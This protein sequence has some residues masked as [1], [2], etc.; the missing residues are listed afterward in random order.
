MGDEDTDM[1]ALAQLQRRAASGAVN[2]GEIGRDGKMRSAEEMRA[3]GI[4]SGNISVLGPNAE[5]MKLS[6]ASRAAR[7]RQ[8]EVVNRFEERRRMAE[9]VVPVKNSDVRALLRKMEQPV[10]LF[11]E[12]E[13]DRRDRLR[14]L[15]AGMDEGQREAVTGQVA[16]EAAILE[17][18]RT[19]QTEA[20]LTVGESRL[21]ETRA[22]LALGSLAKARERVARQKAMTDA[23]YLEVDR[24]Q[25]R[26]AR[27]L[28][29]L[30]QEGS[31]MADERPVSSCQFVPSGDAL[32]CGSWSGNLK[33][34]G[35]PDLAT[36]MTVKAHDDRITGVAMNPCASTS[37]PPG[38]PHYMT[39]CADGTARVWSSSGQLLR[40]LTGHTDR[41]G[42]VAM[43]PDGNLAATASFDRTWR[44][45]DLERGACLY[46]QEGQSRAVYAVAFQCDGS[47]AASSG[48]DAAP[49]V[50]DLR[51]GRCVVVLE[52]H[53]KSVLALDFSPNGYQLVSGSDDHTARVWD[54]R[55]RQCLATLPGHQNLLSTVKFQ[56]G[57]GDYILTAGYDGTAK[58]WSG[59]DF[60]LLKTLAITEG[61]VMSADVCPTGGEPLVATASY[62]RSVK[63]W[64]RGV[65]AE[66]DDADDVAM[67]GRGLPW[68]R[69][70]PQ[71]T[72]SDLALHRAGS[73][74]T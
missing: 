52:G 11:G 8:A 58:L 3:A 27:L 39:G 4:A 65:L 44:L 15:L 5:T 20:F 10:T 31:Q 16:R 53:V 63:L 30:A 54:L 29:S 13:M 21:A 22:R 43:H 9:V 33:V 14:R 40:T 37:L 59:Y 72:P 71:S 2:Y 62:D 64:A 74:A 56:P 57:D 66:L 36:R 7:E 69:T 51:S 1:E 42:R 12:M 60:R 45:W 38:G 24:R 61:K 49:R 26:T 34:L 28:K 41:L 73:G 46:E 18:R 6:D 70:P 19:L 35:V 32:V 67:P 25:A 47:L 23:D 50:W 68:S 55:R 17:D 48:M